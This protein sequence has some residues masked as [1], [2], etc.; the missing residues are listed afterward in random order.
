MT[1]RGILTQFSDHNGYWLCLKSVGNLQSLETCQKYFSKNWASIKKD[2]HSFSSWNKQIKIAVLWVVLSNESAVLLC[3]LKCW[4]VQ[5]C[6]GFSEGRG[7]KTPNQ[8]DSLTATH[9]CLKATAP[10]YSH[11]W[12]MCFKNEHTEKR[13]RRGIVTSKLLK[14]FT[15]CLRLNEFKGRWMSVRRQE[16]DVVKLQENT[17]ADMVYSK[18][19][20]FSL[21][22]F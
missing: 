9:G 7:L 14:S 13:S 11:P 10:N 17:G 5:F 8:G 2:Q 6:L 4:S 22:P 21:A 3:H 15:S 12:C 19:P 18:I 16:V 20:S 1:K